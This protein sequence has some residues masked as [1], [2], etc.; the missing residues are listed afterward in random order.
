MELLYFSCNGLL[1]AAS[2]TLFIAILAGGAALWYRKERRRAGANV[3]GN[4]DGDG[5]QMAVLSLQAGGE[6]EEEGV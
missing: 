3:D 1:G 2:G 6:E 4:A 5:V